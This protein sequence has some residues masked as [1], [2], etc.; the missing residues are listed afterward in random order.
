[1]VYCSQRDGLRG[2]PPT[3]GNGRTKV[4]TPV[5]LNMAGVKPFDGQVTV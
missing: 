3:D 2:L 1:M 4:L 5:M